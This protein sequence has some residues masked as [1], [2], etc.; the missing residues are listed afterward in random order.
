M[1]G[2]VNE[3]DYIEDLSKTYVDT[4]NPVAFSA[5]N[6]IRRVDGGKEKRIKN[7]LNHI[8]SYALHREYKKPRF[9]N[10]WYL[11]SEKDQLQADLIDVQ[12]GAE[13]NDGTTFILSVI[14][15]YTRYAYLG[16]IRKENK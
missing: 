1:T 16:K 8:Y 13:K 4:D 15:P 7:A 12:E 10:K 14:N 6:L 11:Y 2:Q 5:P 9:Y 3:T